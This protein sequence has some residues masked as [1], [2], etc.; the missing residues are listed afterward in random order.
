MQVAQFRRE[1][2]RLTAT[3]AMLTLPEADRL[4]LAEEYQRRSK[5]A[6]APADL[7]PVSSSTR[8]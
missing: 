7:T 3:L 1:N 4:A 6:F 2:E 5:A 8:S